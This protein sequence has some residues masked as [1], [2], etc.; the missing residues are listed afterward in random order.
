VKERGIGA[1][2]VI[3][4]VIVIVAAVGVGGYFLLRGKAT[5]PGGGSANPLSAYALNAGD[6]PWLENIVENEVSGVIENKFSAS[7]LSEW[8][9][10]G[11]YEKGIYQSNPNFHP[12]PSGWGFFDPSWPPRRSVAYQLIM[13]FKDVDGAIECYE[14]AEPLFEN[15]FARGLL[16]ARGILDITPEMLSAI[17]EYLVSENLTFV[18]AGDRGFIISVRDNSSITDEG[19]FL[20]WLQH[21]NLVVGLVIAKNSYIDYSQPGDLVPGITKNNAL[22]LAQTVYNKMIS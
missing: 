7:Q 20:V 11:L 16:T 21:S 13:R 6:M 2:V 1:V 18:S 14:F 19:V 22:A 15:I 17:S 8:G 9:E 3:A 4:I 5:E 12:Y 10:N